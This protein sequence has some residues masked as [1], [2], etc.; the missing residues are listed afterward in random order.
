MNT[1]IQFIVDLLSRH[2]ESTQIQVDTP[3]IIIR[4]EGGFNIQLNVLEKEV[5]VSMKGV[6]WGMSVS[7][8]HLTLPTKRIG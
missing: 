2:F 1:Q 5:L 6:Y 4:L 3:T 7:Y 8:T